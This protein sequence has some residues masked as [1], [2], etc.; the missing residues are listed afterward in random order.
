MRRMYGSS[1]ARVGIVREGLRNVSDKASIRACVDPAL[2]AEVLAAV[3]V[4]KR[5]GHEM[6]INSFVAQALREFLNNE[7]LHRA[8]I[9][10]VDHGA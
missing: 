3:Q 8:I 10:K 9:V 5:L 4:Y 6:T 7:Q 2:R 1:L